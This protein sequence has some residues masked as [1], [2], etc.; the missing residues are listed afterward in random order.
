VAL[1]GVYT[2]TSIV[3]QVIG[4]YRPTVHYKAVVLEEVIKLYAEL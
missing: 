2:S 1:P 3:L 4:T